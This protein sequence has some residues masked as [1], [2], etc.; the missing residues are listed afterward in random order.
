MY[1]SVSDVI[2]FFTVIA[3]VLGLVLTLAVIV[4]RDSEIECDR[5]NTTR[6][7][8]LLLLAVAVGVITLVF[9]RKELQHAVSS[10]MN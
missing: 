5:A 6:A 2:L 7:T 4:K 9:Q 1:W 10:I 3:L 8:L